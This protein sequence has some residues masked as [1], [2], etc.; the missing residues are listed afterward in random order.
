MSKVVDE[1]ERLDKEA[2]SYV[3]ADKKGRWF[4]MRLLDRAR[5][6][7]PTF[8]R[9]SAITAYNEGRRALGLEY[10]AMLTQDVKHITKKQKAEREYASTMSRLRGGRKHV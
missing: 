5:V 7:I 9:K 8:H 4:L 6:N 10:L 1:L 2:L 3:L